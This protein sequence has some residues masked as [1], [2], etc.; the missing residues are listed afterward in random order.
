MAFKFT[1]DYQQLEL[2][3]QTDSTES[4]SSFEHLKSTVQ[5]IDMQQIVAF[6]QLTAA[7]VFIDADTLNRY[8]TAQYNSPNAES[9][10]FTDSDVFD[11]GKASSDTPIIS[12]E[13]AKVLD[14]ALADSASVTE[15]LSRVVQYVREFTDAPALSEAIASLDTAL[16]KEDTTSIAEE[17]A[18]LFETS[19][20]D[21]PTVTEELVQAVDLAK[22]DTPTI[23]DSE[24]LN[25][26]LAKNDSASVA[27]DLASLFS[28]AKADATSISESDVKAVG[29]NVDDG[30]AA[31]QTFTVVVQSYYGANKYYIDGVRQDTLSL[32]VGATYTFDQSDSS[33]AGHP[34]RLSTTS[35]GTH[36]GGSAYTTNVTTNGTAGSSGAYTRIVVTG[37]TPST[38]YYYCTNHS[39]M[40]GQANVSSVGDFSMIESLDRTVTFLRTFTDAAALDDVASA[41]DDLATQ[42]ELVKN[43]VFGFTDSEAKAFSKPGITDS[44]SISEDLS[45]LADLA[46]SDTF[47]AADS[48]PVFNLSLA[49]SDS[50]SISEVVSVAGANTIADI[51]S[52]TETTNLNSADGVQDT[53]AIVETL[54]SEFGFNTSDAVSVAESLAFSFGKTVTDSAT[55]SESVDILFIPGGGSILNSAALNTFVLN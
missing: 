23:T 25:T 33:N 14:K 10:G 55:I 40:G 36:G 6:Q 16:G 26:S 15:E 49:A 39:A 7:D 38:L 13:L 8:F 34:L 3:I 46:P 42:S 45:Y 51:I 1:V 32:K 29:K 9:F 53:T 12:E 50:V 21:T 54:V 5:F 35:N 27:E 52:I 20:S 44:S 17:L 28:A 31:N 24:V 30:Q 48:A 47:G 19:F 11:F 41:T 2:V 18:K 37:S 43:N 4:V 22:A